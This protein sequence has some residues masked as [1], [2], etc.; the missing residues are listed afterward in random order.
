MF[1]RRNRWNRAR[2][3]EFPRLSSA[4][5]RRL[6]PLL[7]DTYR[8]YLQLPY[9][10]GLYATR[11]VA[12][13]GNPQSE[14]RILNGRAT[15]RTETRGQKLQFEFQSRGGTGVRDTVSPLEKGGPREEVAG[16]YTRRIV[17][18]GIGDWQLTPSPHVDI[19]GFQPC[20]AFS[21]CNRSSIGTHDRP[22]LSLSLPFFLYFSVSLSLP[23]SLSRRFNGRRSKIKSS[24]YMY[25]RIK[26]DI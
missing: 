6:Q 1:P 17:A 22:S 14:L 11:I 24:T 23:L 9:R 25:L 4:A 18:H 3:G 21:N 19:A 15:A 26:F 8:A 16:W 5:M 20:S 10:R 12:A 2:V 7:N 13:R